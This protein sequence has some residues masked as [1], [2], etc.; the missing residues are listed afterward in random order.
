MP[1]HP[2]VLSPLPFFRLNSSSSIIRF[3]YFLFHGRNIG[4]TLQ[5]HKSQKGIAAHRIHSPT[6]VLY[7]IA[8]W[9]IYMLVSTNVPSLFPAV[10]PCPRHKLLPRGFS[11]CSLLTELPSST[12]SQ[13]FFPPPPSPNLLLNTN[14]ATIVGSRSRLSGRQENVKTDPEFLINLVSSLGLRG[15]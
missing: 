1:C 14:L 4:E 15:I 3:D 8:S 5:R 13:L 6:V 11:S 7:E 12:C 2:V 10:R 9:N